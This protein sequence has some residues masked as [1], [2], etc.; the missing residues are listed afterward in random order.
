MKAKAQPL[1]KELP[2]LVPKS[3][4]S[5]SEKQVQVALNRQATFEPVREAVIEAAG[6]ERLAAELQSLAMELE[7]PD[8]DD[9]ASVAAAAEAEKVRQKKESHARYM[10][11]FR[12]LRSALAQV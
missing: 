5:A 11:F 8:E 2:A 3:E 10:R 6:K 7:A 4:A 9:S 12:S 1:A